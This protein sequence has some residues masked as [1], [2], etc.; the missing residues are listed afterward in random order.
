M[1][2]SKN[3]NGQIVLLMRNDVSVETEQLDVFSDFRSIGP[4]SWLNG[5][6]PAELANPGNVLVGCI[7]AT[8]FGGFL[9]KVF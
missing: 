1:P 2:N 4:H 7:S 6:Q 5:N 9:A 8:I 3:S